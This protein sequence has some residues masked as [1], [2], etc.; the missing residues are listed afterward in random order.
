MRRLTRIRLRPGAL[1]PSGVKVQRD[2]GQRQHNGIAGCLA[3]GELFEINPTMG[4]GAGTNTP[5]A[6]ERALVWS[7]GPRTCSQCPLCSRPSVCK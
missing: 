5:Y 2:Q 3:T 7:Q 1:V 4:L 6:P